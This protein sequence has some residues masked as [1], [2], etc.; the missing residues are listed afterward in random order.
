MTRSSTP[1]TFSDDIV[2]FFI[3]VDFELDDEIIGFWSGFG[4]LTFGERT[5]DGAG[6]IMSV[7]A[8]NEHLEISADGITIVFSGLSSVDEIGLEDDYQYRRCNLYVGS[9]NNYPSEVQT[10]KV[11]S[12]FLDTISI[13]DDGETST[14]TIKAE[15]RLLDLER[16]RLQYYTDESQKYLYP[17]IVI[18]TSHPYY[19]LAG[20]TVLPPDESLEGIAGI[21]E[22]Q[23]KWGTA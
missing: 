3:A 21:Q 17:G 18:D 8:I 16:P 11:F 14:V 7:S 1:S 23:V 12:G 4:E 5:Y 20:V 19:A 13:T 15:N 22:K 9:L 10:Y 2:K 6:N